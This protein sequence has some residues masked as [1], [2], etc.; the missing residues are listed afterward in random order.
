MLFRSL[1]TLHVPELKTNLIS[2]GTLDSHGYKYIGENSFLEI[3]KGALVAMKEKFV[4]GLN[5][6]L[7]KAIM[8]IL[9]VF[10]SLELSDM[11]STS[12]GIYI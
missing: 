2:I 5:H 8:G 9:A 10:S 6:L 4:N 7:D 1:E 12:Y 11:H 3:F